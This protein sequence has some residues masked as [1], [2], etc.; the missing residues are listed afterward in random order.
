MGI[1]IKTKEEI[2]ILREGG[3]RLAVILQRVAA[4]VRAGVS[5]ATLNDLALKLMKEGGD[6]P[7]FLGY[8]PRGAKRPFPAALCVSVNDEVVHGIPNEEE[9]ILKEGDIVALDAGLIHKGLFTDMAVTVPVGKIDAGAETLLEVTKKAL[10]IGIKEVK[11]GAVTG[12]IGA[13]I[14]KFVEP[15][16]FGIVRDL[17]GHGVGYGVHEDPFVPNFGTKGEGVELKAGMVLALEPML[18]VGSAEVVLDSDGYTYR[19]HDGTRSAHFEA[20]VVVT[21]KGSEILTQV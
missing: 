11:A 15:H 13:A 19:T 4:E 17:A 8:K 7:S 2:T 10:A 12:D 1:T 21:E 14:Q 18:N 16:G 6:T 9:K 3:R 5:S 20:T